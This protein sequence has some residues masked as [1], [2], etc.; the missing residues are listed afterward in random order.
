MAMFRTWVLA[1]C[2]IAGAFARDTSVPTARSEPWSAR[3]AAAYLDSRV[4]WWIDWSH[5]GRDHQTFCVSCHTVVPY[6]MARASLRGDLEEQA[7]SSL[8][9]TVLANVT[10]RVRM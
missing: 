6:V 2:F 1:C 10:K 8:E 5:A 3:D 7:P 9:R 4:S